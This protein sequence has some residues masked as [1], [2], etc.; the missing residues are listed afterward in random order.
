MSINS[1]DDILSTL[2]KVKSH[3]NLKDFFDSEEDNRICV[4]LVDDYA[5]KEDLEEIELGAS[6][7]LTDHTGLLNRNAETKLNKAG[8][9]LTKVKSTN[10]AASYLITSNNFTFLFDCY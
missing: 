3:A 5:L 4:A 7:F 6:H 10:N 8:Y 1:V 2:N 9:S